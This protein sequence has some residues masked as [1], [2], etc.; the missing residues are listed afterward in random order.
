MFRNR[1]AAG[2]AGRKVR[3]PSVESWQQSSEH[4]WKLVPYF[5]LC[6]SKRRNKEVDVI[7]YFVH[8]F[9]VNMKAVSNYNVCLCII[10]CVAR[11]ETFIN[12]PYTC[13]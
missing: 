3:V 6:I 8:T 1:T 9:N 11:T 2:A 10:S 13:M 5:V 4:G 12:A 7:L